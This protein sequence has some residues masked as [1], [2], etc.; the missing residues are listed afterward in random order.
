MKLANFRNF[1]S[2]SIGKALSIMGH[3]TLEGRATKKQPSIS[4]V[5]SET[6]PVMFPEPWGWRL[7]WMSDPWQVT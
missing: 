6:S 1:Q 3:S 2:P 5:L 7:L 4:P